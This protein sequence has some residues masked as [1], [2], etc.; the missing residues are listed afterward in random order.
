M[1]LPTMPPALSNLRLPAPIAAIA[2]IL[3]MAGLL[4]LAIMRWGN[5]LPPAILWSGMA[6]LL[7]VLIIWLV[8][9]G[10]PWWR[11]RQFLRQ[12]KQDFGGVAGTADKEPR[13]DLT[14]AA[15]EAVATLNGLDRST[16]ARLPWLFVL[17]DMVAAR[18]AL[19][20][21][22]REG[23]LPPPDH[24]THPGRLWHHWYL[25]SGVAV[26][27]SDRF[28]CPRT[29]AATRRLWLHALLT[30]NRL[31][32]HMPLHGLV[33]LIPVDLLLPGTDHRQQERLIDLRRMIDEILRTLSVD[34]PLYVLISGIDRL[35]GGESFLRLLP[36]ATRNQAVG[37][38]F[39]DQ[40]PP[41]RALAEWQT[42]FDSLCTTLYR[43]QLGL[44][45]ATSVPADRQAI[46]TFLVRVERLRE[47]LAAFLKALFDSGAVQLQRTARPRGIYLLG[48]DRQPAFAD[49]LF[50]TV[51]PRDAALAR[52]T[53]GARK[54]GRRL[55]LATAGAALAMSAIVT[56]GIVWPVGK[57]DD[58]RQRAMQAC[59]AD[60]GASTLAGLTDCA[61]QIARFDDLA[62][63]QPFGSRKARADMDALRTVWS[64]AWKAAVADGL[65]GAMKQDIDHDFG[66]RLAVLEQL[67]LLDACTGNQGQ[68]CTDAATAAVQTRVRLH[69]MGT[70]N[71]KMLATHLSYLAWQSRTDR[72]AAY[73]R[74]LALRAA[75]W[76]VTPP[77][78][79]DLLHWANGLGQPR[80]LSRFWDR[81]GEEDN[82]PLGAAFTAEAWNKGVRP[83]FDLIAAQSGNPDLAVRL[84]REF[85]QARQ[86][87]W[88]GFLA[89]FGDGVGL[90]AKDNAGL[91]NL[92]ASRNRH[93][94]ET[95]W[96]E[97]QASVLS[98]TPDDQL[99]PWARVMK[100]ALSTQ[101]PQAVGRL[102]P[103]GASLAQ[104]TDNQTGYDLASDAF[105]ATGSPGAHA[106]Q[107]LWLTLEQFRPLRDQLGPDAGQEDHAALNALEAA[108]RTLLWVA[109]QDAAARI[110]DEW[111]TSILARTRSQQPA[112]ASALLEGAQGDVATFVR[113][114]LSPFLTPDSLRPR[115]T[116]G[117]EMSIDPAFAAFADQMR[118]PGAPQG[119]LPIGTLSVSGATR[120]GAIMEGPLGTQVEVLCQG[121]VFAATSPGT[122]LP[123]RVNLLGQRGDCREVHVTVSLPT[124][125]GQGE[126]LLIT[127]SWTGENALE[128][129]A[130]E[131]E[132]GRQDFRLSSFKQRMTAAASQRLREVAGGDDALV[133]VMADI[134]LTAIGR[135]EPSSSR[136]IP[137]RVL[138]PVL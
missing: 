52:C 9:R 11:E 32:P 51:I 56:A 135:G 72:L 80:S 102:L 88:A 76:T 107:P 65:Y 46:H 95:L 111:S 119:P 77:S 31:R 83:A 53:G 4:G 75:G 90:W 7:I 39:A 89:R 101:W 3:L 71:D 132:K 36:E 131:F 61:D 59:L 40:T 115:K 73:E 47:P 38:C 37:H 123:R 42:A 41:N 13:R 106:S 70:G 64:A 26:E 43:L 21:A 97:L 19:S 91:K 129:F 15:E 128:Q 127:R 34:I 10:W 66:V 67:S 112:P 20:H 16:A 78:I 8:F 27:I 45:S 136:A 108:P 85:H 63:S 124:E 55:A 35:E 49:D 58:A 68:R 120:I 81:P 104:A 23:S 117:L 103:V 110:N 122:T 2:G 5:R 25:A 79:A 74:L 100:E 50:R 92:L 94:F 44:L 87:D 48:G 33:L 12:F 113:T 17:G 84:L 57:L 109:M 60:G 96:K 125:L 137:S 18:A 133:T 14:I 69:D 114:W 62:N 134:H 98:T 138:Q 54:R 93:P 121:S 28:I 105:L 126:A 6:V 82:R 29:E 130:R 30:A 22:T 86:E 24:A 118:Q 1:K 99:R 116:I